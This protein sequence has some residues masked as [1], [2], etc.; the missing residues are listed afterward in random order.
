VLPHIQGAPTIA[1]APGSKIRKTTVS[2][3]RCW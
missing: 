3:C 1:E 2:L